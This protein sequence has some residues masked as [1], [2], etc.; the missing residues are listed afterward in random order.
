[1]ENYINKPNLPSSKVSLGLVDG[2]IRESILCN[3]H[4][5]GI[6]TIKTG[7][8]NELYEAV[9][10]HPDMFM[11]HLY[12]NNMVVAPNAPN[13]TVTEL[14]GLGFNI[15][16][17][18]KFVFGKYP[19]DVAYNVARIG[20]YAICNYQYTDRVLLSLL[21]EINVKIIDVKQGYSKCSI[22]IIDTGILITSDE[23][24]Y[25]TL[26]KWDFD[27]LKLR[28]GYI[29]LPG[30][31]YGFIGGAAG[32]VSENT[33]SFMGNIMFHPDFV[34]INDFL[35]NRGKIIVNLDNEKL[36]DLGTFIPLKEYCI[37]EI[38]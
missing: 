6:K 3:L 37:E 19:Y 4:S 2:R 7:K 10:Y 1:M 34:K 33:I 13:N 32:L 36:V 17:G 29:E 16:N 24:I 21:D 35:K 15:I 30:M 20:N 8:C 5:I 28:A 9:S 11:H 23:G 18:E 26:L 31:N 12:D 27:I 38:C 22:C 14:R 25:K